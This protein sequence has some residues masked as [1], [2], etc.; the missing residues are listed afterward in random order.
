MKHLRLACYRPAA[1]CSS[2][3]I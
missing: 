3:F 1:L 2:K